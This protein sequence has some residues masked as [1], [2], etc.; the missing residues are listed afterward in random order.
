MIGSLLPDLVSGRYRCSDD[1]VVAA[2]I[3][4][5]RRVDVFTDTHRCFARSKAR[6]F[7]QHGRFSG[8][9]VDVFYDHLLSVAWDRHVTEPRAAFIARCYAALGAN[10][11]LM[12][13]PMRTPI[14][15]MIE[16]DWL[17]AYV[18]VEG[19]RRILAMMS[20]RFT[21]RFGRTVRLEQAVED[22]ALH[23]AGLTEDFD[24]FYPALVAAM[25]DVPAMQGVP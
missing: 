13:P 5:H 7:E 12:P 3:E 4:R 23:R 24:E 15:R 21:Q 19:L 22:L 16:Q 10:L 6:L 17:G 2:A 9:V 25:A 14:T 1:P 18:E 8:I 11:R 20:W